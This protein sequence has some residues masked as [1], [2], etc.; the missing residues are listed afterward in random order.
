MNRQST[1]HHKS[2]T[3]GFSLIEALVALAVLTLAVA[4]PL[5]AASDGVRGAI[6]AKDQIIAVNL[7]QEAIEAARNTR[8]SYRLGGEV[9]PP[10]FVNLC[11]GGADCRVDTTTASITIELC[12]GDA[13]ILNYNSTSGAYNHQ[14]ILGNVQTKFTRIL[15]TQIINTNGKNDEVLITVTVSWKTSALPT[16]TFVVQENLLNWQ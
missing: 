2:L 7:A 10:P 8:D 5:T 3:K 13:C 1:T 15:E 6:Y 11:T 14:E 16:R 4:G 9:W 12:S